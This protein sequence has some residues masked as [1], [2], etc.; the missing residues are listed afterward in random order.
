[1]KKINTTKK[2]LPII[3]SRIHDLEELARVLKIPQKEINKEYTFCYEEFQQNYKNRD[4]QFY[5]DNAIERVRETYN[6]K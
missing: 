3:A 6:K 4:I 2:D 1:M 5:H